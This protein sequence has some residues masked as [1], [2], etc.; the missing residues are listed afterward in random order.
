MSN[1]EQT[2]KI[3]DVIIGLEKAALDRWYKGDPDGYLEIYDEEDL[4]YFDPPKDK[5]LDGYSNVKAFYDSIKGLVHSEKYEILNPL[6]QVLTDTSATLS[7]NL[8][9]YVGND[10]NNWNLSSVFK[11]N[12]NNQWKIIHTHWSFVRPM[13]IS[14]EKNKDII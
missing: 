9:A 6:V 12:K 4:S 8:V 13:D 7:Y 14:F 5:R 11:L 2:K 3:A 10:I 1:S